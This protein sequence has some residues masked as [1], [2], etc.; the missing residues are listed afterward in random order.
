MSFQDLTYPLNKSGQNEEFCNEESYT[1]RSSPDSGLEDCGD[2]DNVFN[3]L[4][5]SSP[6]DDD[7]LIYINFTP[8][9]TPTT[10]TINEE[11]TM[12][13]R[14]D[15]VAL[16]KQLLEAYLSDIYLTKDIF[17]LKHFRK[18]KDGW[19]SVKLMS[20]YKRLKRTAT[21]ISEVEDAVGLSSIL[22]LNSDKSKLRRIKP[23][24]NCIDKYIPTR[25]VMLGDLNQEIRNLASLAKLASKYGSVIFLHLHRPGG[26][27]PEKMR[28]IIS[29][30]P[31]LADYWC[32]LVE[33]ENID[34]ATRLVQTFTHA[35]WAYEIVVPW[36]NTRNNE[37]SGSTSSD[38]ISPLPSPIVGRHKKHSFMNGYSSPG[39][40][41]LCSP[42]STKLD[43]PFSFKHSFPN[44]ISGCKCRQC[45]ILDTYNESLLEDEMLHQIILNDDYKVHQMHIFPIQ[46]CNSNNTKLS[47]TSISVNISSPKHTNQITSPKLIRLSPKKGSPKKY[48]TPANTSENWRS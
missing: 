11:L 36:K 35:S 7:Y 26:N 39:Y 16:I 9:E 31:E 32:A 24:P 13:E 23:I 14:E 28:E 22:E 47:P 42:N 3:V 37:R 38:C 45:Q 46:S 18:S 27:I 30:K 34:S 43:N 15:R 6:S 29:K 10:P 19:I 44:H 8:P 48:Q 40:S 4:Q 12:M 2:L 1:N 25:L 21:K 5:I 41:P 17:L 20:T 33:F